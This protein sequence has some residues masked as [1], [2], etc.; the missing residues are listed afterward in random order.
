MPRIGYLVSQYPAVSHTF[1]RREIQ[2]LRRRGLAI[3]TFSVR[4]PPESERLGTAD[5][6]ERARTFYILPVALRSLLVA[7]LA[8]AARRPLAYFATLCE[9]LRHRVPGLRAWLWSLFYFAEAIVLARELERR[10]IAHLHNHFGNPGANVGMLACRFLGLGWSLTLHAISEFDYPYGVMLPRKLRAARFAACVSSYTMAQ[11]MRICDPADWTKL[12]VVR[13]GVN[14]AALPA[15]ERRGSPPLRVLCVARLAP[16]KGHLGLID[17]FAQVLE[18]GLAAQLRLV[19]DGPERARIEARIAERGIDKHCMVLGQRSE[20]E[21]LDEIACADVLV[22]ASFMEGLPVVLM[23]ALGLGVPVVAPRIAGIP[24]LVEDGVCG[25]LFTPADWDE[26]GRCLARLL[27]D[28]QL[29]ARLADA[30]A[31]RVRTEFDADRACVPLHARLTS[32]A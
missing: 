24:E 22:N 28:P 18:R 15:R 16:E 1:I 32:L 23:E 19:G 3:D 7:H 9:S 21:A 25:L 29:R 2:A 20:E 12:F 4:R 17:A 31:A 6:E 11:A 5:Q 30:G 26:L 8:A 14:F 13:C 10:G 27:G